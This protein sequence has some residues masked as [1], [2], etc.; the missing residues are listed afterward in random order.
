MA[1][2]AV[3]QMA[4]VAT[5]AD[6]KADAVIKNDCILLKDGRFPN[7]GLLECMAQ[8]MALW[9]CWQAIKAGRKPRPGFLL[10][11]R[12]LELFCSD[13]PVG[14]KIWLK[15]RL[16]LL[17]EEGLGQFDCEARRDGENGE[18]LARAAVNAYQPNEEQAQKFI[19]D[20][21]E[22]V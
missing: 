21:E 1:A 14:S 3:V 9:S 18:L 15:A 5:A 22:I 17:T 12:N 8:T 6:A 7:Y 13:L 11:T 20:A 16:V 10:G 19:G 2:G 4:T